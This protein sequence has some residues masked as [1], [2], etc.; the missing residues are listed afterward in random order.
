MHLS[1][2]DNRQLAGGDGSQ[3]PAIA[4][5]RR[6]SKSGKRRLWP[7]TTGLPAGTRRPE[8]ETLMFPHTL[9]T[10]LGQSCIGACKR[11]CNYRV[12][13][14]MCGVTC[15]LGAH[16]VHAGLREDGCGL[17]PPQNTPTITGN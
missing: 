10:E 2:V 9:F 1:D 15:L 11:V 3:W 14:L 7:A 12:A 16:S 5:A 4:G 17:A 6:T 8:C 13:S